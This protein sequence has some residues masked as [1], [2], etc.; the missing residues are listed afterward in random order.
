[1]IHQY[2]ILKPKASAEESKT[3]RIRALVLLGIIFQFAF[4]TLSAQ[5]VLTLDDAMNIAIRNS[6]EIIKSE[7]NMTISKENLK[8]REA[9]TK[10]LFKFQ[11]T[12]FY[13]DQNR[14]F[15]SLFSTW[16]TNETKR[17]YGDFIVSQPLLLTDGRISLQN[18]LEYQDAFSD[19][20][21]VRSKGYNNNLFLK[22]SQPIFTYNKLKMEINELKLA[23]ENAT[24]SYSIQRPF[25]EKQVSQYFYTV[26]Q[27]QLALTIAQDEL[28]NRQESFNIIQSKVEGGL[29]AKEE[30]FQAELNLATSESNLQNKQV[31]LDNAKDQFKQYIGIPLNEDFDIL[32]DIGFNKVNVDVYKAIQNGLETRMEL[33]QREI[34]I[35]NS[36]NDLT[37]AKSTNE[38]AGSVDLSVGLF[39]ED[40]RL[41]NVYD[42]PT[43]SPQVQVTFNIPIYD[44]GE[45]R[46]RIKAAEASIKIQELNLET[47]RTNVEIG[48][49]QTYRSLQ[50]LDMQIELAKQNEKNAQLTYEINLERYKNGDLTSMDLNLFQNQ[51]SEKKM[52]LTN[53]L[54][55]YKLELL[56]LKIQSL[57]D[58]ENNSS[59]VPVEIQENIEGK[60]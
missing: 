25:L 12:P 32:T 40:A 1:M 21:N 41:P 38:F 53:S 9:A 19:Y 17:V 60:E 54:I 20:N 29:S 27:R 14:S 33:K 47:E 8:A 10:S 4:V 35:K 49:R 58:F 59:F 42:R 52:N 43:R 18:H 13:Y 39:G 50:N 30:L 15:N 31:D 5:K 7:L 55:S 45:R 56:N 48:I 16:N 26:Y 44:W 28:K 11:F 37:V 3:T 2:R 23:L 51:L 34:D 57:W 22:Y 46:S 6:P 24:L 36:Y